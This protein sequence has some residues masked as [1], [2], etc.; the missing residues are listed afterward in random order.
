MVPF[1][2]SFVFLIDLYI[3]RKGKNKLA[4]NLLPTLLLSVFL[5]SLLIFGRTTNIHYYVA[6]YYQ[7]ILFMSLGALFSD[8][9]FI[10]ANFVILIGVVVAIFLS[11]HVQQ[12]NEFSHFVQTGFM[13]FLFAATGIFL[14]IFFLNKFQTEALMVSEEANSKTIEIGELNNLVNSVN[15]VSNELKSHAI[16]LTNS[17][18]EINE[19][20][21][22]QATNIEEISTSVEEITQTIVQGS[23]NAKNISTISINALEYLNDLKIGFENYKTESSRINDFTEEIKKIAEKTDI[24]AINAS[25]EASRAGQFSGGFKVIADEVRK[26][27]EISRNT[28]ESVLVIGSGISQS[29]ANFAEKIDI[30]NVKMDN[31]THDI[32]FLANGLDEERLTLGYINN[33]IAQLNNDA[34]QNAFIASK[35]LKSATQLQENS[36]VLEQ[37]LVK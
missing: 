32:E 23:A 22:R 18:I 27:A 11:Y 17:Q 37:I 30:I 15:K 25:I 1:V 33:A 21:T 4:G 14:V 19:A 28:A 34:Q 2:L 29:A 26:L 31:L 24:L 6:G 9:R 8:R 36:F 3:L 5:L 7:A 20:V 12:H 13:N 16:E 35:V 10:T